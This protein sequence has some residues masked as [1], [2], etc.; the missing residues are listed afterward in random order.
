MSQ[1][2][3]DHVLAFF[4]LCIN[5]SVAPFAHFWFAPPHLR[6][7]VCTPRRVRY[8]NVKGSWA[9]DDFKQVVPHHRLTAEC[10]AHTKTWA[11]CT[12]QFESTCSNIHQPLFALLDFVNLLQRDDFQRLPLLWRGKITCYTARAR[13]INSLLHC[14]PTMFRFYVDPFLF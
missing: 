8:L 11:A 12:W 3:N 14:V 4:P 6:A 13:C 9:G 2:S 5:I 10:R 1:V 7:V